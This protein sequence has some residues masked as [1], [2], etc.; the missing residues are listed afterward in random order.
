MMRNVK[1]LVLTILKMNIFS[2]TFEFKYFFNL[3][4]TAMPRD[5]LCTKMIMK[6]S[7]T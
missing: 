3:L 1:N 6:S 4:L 2:I 5:P 7:V